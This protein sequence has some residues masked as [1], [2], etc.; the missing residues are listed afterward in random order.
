MKQTNGKSK[1]VPITNKGFA[2]F[3]YTSNSYPSKALVHYHG[4]HNLANLVLPHGNS[5]LKKPPFVRTMPSLLKT[6]K[7]TPGRPNTVYQKLI[8]QAPK[9]ILRHRAEAPRNLIQIQNAQ[10][11]ERRKHK[12]SQCEVWS[13]KILSSAIPEFIKHLAIVPDIEVIC[14]EPNTLELFANLLTT[15]PLSKTVRSIGLY[16]DTTFKC[17]D[18]YLSILSFEQIEFL[19]TPTIPLFYFMHNRKFTETHCQLWSKFVS[20]VPQLKQVISSKNPRV[21]LYVATD[22]EDAITSAIANLLPEV[23]HY[24]CQRHFY[25]KCER[26]LH[27]LRLKTNQWKTY[28]A[29][30]EELFSMETRKLYDEKFAEFIPKWNKVK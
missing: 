12:I 15:P 23:D 11:I 1:S 4:D 16:Y 24:F 22:E 5:K 29:Q 28:R 9:D 21:K 27:G 2:R 18:F 30:L 26:F 13:L 10:K 8:N 7:K 25:K 19:P 14:A 17:G 3:V 20:C 6:I